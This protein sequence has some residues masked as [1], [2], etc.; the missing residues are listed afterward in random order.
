[1]CNELHKVVWTTCLTHAQAPGRAR[2]PSYDLAMRPLRRPVA[3]L[4][5][6]LL[7]VAVGCGSPPAT[8]S[9]GSGEA[10]AGA[11]AGDC[12][13]ESLDLLEDGVLT[14]ATDSP[15]YEPWFSEDD[16]TNGQGFESAVA[17]AVAEQ[18]GFAED[19]VTWVEQP[20]NTSYAPGPKKFDFDINQISITPERQRVVDFSRGYYS[21][22]QAVVALEG[23][24]IEPG[25]IADLK[26]LRLGAQTGTTSLT[27][28]REVVQPD[29]EPVVL[30]NTNIAKQQ[31]LNGQLDAIVADLPTAFYITGAEIEGSAVVGQFEQPEG[32]TEEFGLLLQKDSPLTPCVDEALAALEDDGTLAE[33]EQEWLSDTVD[34]PV[35][36]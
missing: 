13:P 17:Y 7:A 5:P 8:D 34:V 36:Q 35:L 22:S 3:L 18:L 2:A 19:E 25:S 6:L 31:L 12:A 11:E 32:E 20:F 14:V 33:L 27:A 28:L 10:S 1:M 15:A 30:Q 29:T 4:A 26:E 16:P 23:S 24:G 9:E 21:A